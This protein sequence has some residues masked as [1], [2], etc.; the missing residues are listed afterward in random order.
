MHWGFNKKNWL[1]QSAVN[2]KICISILIQTNGSFV[3]AFSLFCSENGEGVS[4]GRGE[5]AVFH[6]HPQVIH[7]AIE[8]RHK[9]LFSLKI[10]W[11][12]DYWYNGHLG[13]R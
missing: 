3:F 4:E 5:V 11:L 8:E 7:T 2:F 6:N 9:S 13:R 1:I 10:N 12:E